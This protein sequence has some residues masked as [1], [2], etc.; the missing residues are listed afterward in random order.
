MSINRLSS[1]DWATKLTAPLLWTKMNQY[2][3]GCNIMINKW[4]NLWVDALIGEWVSGERAP[5]RK[6]QTF[7]QDIKFIIL[8]QRNT[9]SF[10]PSAAHNMG[11]FFWNT[12][13]MHPIGPSVRFA[14]YYQLLWKPPT[15]KVTLSIYPRSVPFN[16]VS[17]QYLYA[18]LVCPLHATCLSCPSF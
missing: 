9:V 5:I 10:T 18:F 7:T 16:K 3:Y 13:Q 2:V 6:C 15:V 8:V 11:A 14:R 4:T 17:F 12:R 1:T